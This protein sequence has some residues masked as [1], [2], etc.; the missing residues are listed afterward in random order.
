[1]KIEIRN[2]HVT[3]EGYVNAVGRDSRVMYDI[4]GNKFVEQVAPGTFERALNKGNDIEIRLN[5]EK[6]IGSVANGNLSLYEDSIGLYAHAEISDAEF[7]RA[8]EKK[9]LSGW[10]F[11][12]TVKK[13]RFEPTS[14]E[15]TE[16][17]ILEDIN[18]AEVSVLSNKIPAYYGTNVETRGED[19]QYLQIRCIV[20]DKIEFNDKT[21]HDENK[22]FHA[23]FYSQTEKEIEILKM[24]K[25]GI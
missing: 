10:S 11:G 4:K 6:V 3:V 8:A 25:R 21:Q 22:E 18:L 9:Q 13:D 5:H 24:K 20:D 17:R 2:N 16:R 7:V 19:G 14:A 15:D 23:V 12:F 1:M